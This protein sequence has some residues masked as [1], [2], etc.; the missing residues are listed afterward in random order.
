MKYLIIA[1]ST[2]LFITPVTDLDAE[3]EM[4]I[5]VLEAPP[6]ISQQPDGTV[7]GIFYDRLKCIFERMQKPFSVEMQP[8]KRAQAEVLAGRAAG[9]APASREDIRD[10]Y[11][12]FSGSLME[13]KSYFYYLKSATLEPQDPDYKDRA[14]VSALIGSTQYQDLQNE[15][16]TLGPLVQNFENLFDLVERKRVEAVLAPAVLAEMILKARG[17]LN[18]YKKHYYSSR[19]SG[20]YF[21]NGY[22][23][24]HPGFLQRFNKEIG[25][26]TL[27]DS[28]K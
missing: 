4:K 2:I 26:C 16:Y 17:T 23:D 3:D 21:A 19:H 13:V 6:F 20:V 11:A 8:W 27:E 5:F 25:G 24:K 22:L 15:N 10:T 18:N 1:L 9:F 14:K 12:T 28:S 7:T